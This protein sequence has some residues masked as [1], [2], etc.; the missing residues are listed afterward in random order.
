ML[1]CWCVISTHFLHRTDLMFFDI[2]SR[3]VR[4]VSANDIVVIAVDDRTVESLGGW[5][6]SESIH[7]RLIDRLT[8][9]KAAAVGF[10][11]PTAHAAQSTDADRDALANAI[12]R[13]GRVVTR[14]VRG[15]RSGAHAGEQR[16]LT[17]G[18]IAYASGHTEVQQ[19]DD[20][21]VRGFS[22]FAGGAHR[23]RH[24]SALLLEA[25]G[26]RVPTCVDR[27]ESVAAA[28]E[29]DCIRYVPL[30][31]MRS[32]KTYS[33]VDVLRGRVPA[34]D[35]AGRIVLVGATADG[36]A[37]RLATPAVDGSPLTNVEFLAE[38]TDALMTSS[39]VRP[40][41]YWCQL[42]WS[43]G[44][45]P[46]TCLLLYLLGPRAGLLA[47][48]L[49][50]GMM[51]GSSI[52]MLKFGHL[53][54]SP[55]AGMLTCAVAYPLWAWRRQ[56]AL[57]NYLS[58]EAAKGAKEPSLPEAPGPVTFFNDPVQRQLI[59][60]ASLFDRVRRHREFIS[61]WVDS[62][63]EATL[64]T[65]PAGEVIL[66]NERVIALCQSSELRRTGRVSPA[67][68][69][70]SDVLF[71]ITAS[72]RAIEF[73]SQ[74]LALFALWSD[75]EDPPAY[76]ESMFAQ[77]IEIT[78]ARGGRS[79]LIKCAQ[80]K[81]S[82]GRDGALIFHLADVSS[83]R[84][85]ERQRDTALRFLSHDMR[86]PQA[87]ILALVEQMQQ[88]PSRFT[89][90]QFSTLV[91]QYATTALSLADDF[92][93][94]A[95]A[96]SLP[97][98]LTRVDPALVLGDAIDDLWPQ[99]TAQ[100]TTVNLVAEPGKSTIADVQLL[101]RAFANLIGN[102][103][104]FSPRYSTVDVQLA[105]TDRHLKISVIDRGVG[106][107]EH[108]RKAL[109]REFSQL[110]EKFSRSGHGLGLAFVKTVVDSLGGQLQ[111]DSVFGRGT[112]F[113]VFL[114]KLNGDHSSDSAA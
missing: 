94:L 46:L 3:I 97:P 24:M 32:Y 34:G 31:D 59:A 20:G 77:G 52:A 108:E 88:E 84:K 92:L 86:S 103:I 76:S 9:S 79:L 16:A 45:V 7:A 64:V 67:G 111:V 13:N 28:D 1:L 19:D 29:D 30:G 39:L 17:S 62:L 10:D 11:L 110:D 107:P 56:E 66:A 114:P 53:F 71:E 48:F 65:T 15:D 113:M 90:R 38:A 12:R 99:A 47:S 83:V 22:M 91:G 58:L 87:A 112:T 2:A 27:N 35:L 80:I 100:S 72:H 8:E 61:A 44:A 33:Y 4:R 60:T 89:A 98:K 78:N 37:T 95:R 25:A 42:I 106:I 69:A 74:A 93:F 40:A 70:V 6:L 81:P 82:A 75:D 21:I 36:I 54:L 102:A 5:P 105:E 101:R 51:A 104:K 73:A 85:A 96:E 50:A 68:R 18:G 57:L 41:G 109:F 23:Y 43:E 49:L 55:C 14:R 63:P 26:F